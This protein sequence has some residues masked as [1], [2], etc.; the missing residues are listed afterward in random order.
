M[1]PSELTL[2]AAEAA[3]DARAPMP[4]RVAI[5]AGYDELMSEGERK[6]LATQCGLCHGIA[7]QAEH[8]PH[9]ALAICCGA[10]E[11]GGQGGGRGAGPPPTFDL[12][13]AAGL[14]QWR[15][16]AWQAADGTPLSVLAMP[17]AAAGQLVY[18]SPEAPEVLSELRRSEVYIIGGL[19]DRHKKHG[20]SLRR[21]TALGIRCARLPLLENLPA[22]MRGRSNALDALN[23]NSAF[24]LLVEWSK[25]R[26]WTSAS[27]RARC[28]L[29]TPRAASRELRA[30]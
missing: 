6:S 17:G 2:A 8:R 16:L 13:C 25:T 28:E 1:V 30:P 24:R 3:L 23:L 10:A 29:Q 26:E 11:G 22:E 9:V 5:D 15:P 27:E 4:L 12:L 19:V 21:A 14:E 7:S 20:A 18:L